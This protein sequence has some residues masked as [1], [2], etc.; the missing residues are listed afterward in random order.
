MQPRFLEIP[1]QAK[2]NL[3]HDVLATFSQ[4]IPVSA[5]RR[6]SAMWTRTA[7]TGRP[8]GTRSADAAVG[9]RT[10]SQLQTLSRECAG[11]IIIARDYFI[12]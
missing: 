6:G 8:A 1:E 12:C 7:G 2:K 10:T 3:L 9:A 11:S 4:T 5:A